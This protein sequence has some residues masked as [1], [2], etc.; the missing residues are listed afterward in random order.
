MMPLAV[1]VKMYLN[2]F[3]AVVNWKVFLPELCG[4]ISLSHP[5]FMDSEIVI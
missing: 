5:D 3:F 1:G 2:L 4:K